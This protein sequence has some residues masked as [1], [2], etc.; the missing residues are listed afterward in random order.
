[1]GILKRYIAVLNEH[2]AEGFV[3]MFFFAFYNSCDVFHF[4]VNTTCYG[5]I[6]FIKEDTDQVRTM[7]S[8]CLIAIIDHLPVVK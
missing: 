6:K 8:L 3:L 5:K 1:M 4:Q 7:F 2:F